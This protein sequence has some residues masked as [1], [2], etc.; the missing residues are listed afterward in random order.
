MT[1]TTPNPIDD[2]PPTDKRVGVPTD[3][4][5]F[6]CN[7]CAC[8]FRVVGRGRSLT[9][10]A[11]R[12]TRDI[13]FDT[14]CCHQCSSYD[15]TGHDVASLRGVKRMTTKAKTPKR[16]A[17]CVDCGAVEAVKVKIGSVDCAKCGGVCLVAD[18][19]PL[20]VG[21]KVEP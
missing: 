9:K 15:V 4:D 7:S 2:L 10:R 16:V 5:L 20:P 19:E 13:D 18:V 1:T 11:H 12:R 17:V 3:Y 21:E 6:E 14:V 8:R